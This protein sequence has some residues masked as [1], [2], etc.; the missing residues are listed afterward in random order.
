V[1][2]PRFNAVPG[3]A[4][5]AASGDVLG[6]DAVA[7]LIDLLRIDTSNPGDDSGPGEIAAAEYAADALREVGYA[8]EVFTTSAAHRAG[9]SLLIPG[10]DPAREPLLL[11]G[12][13]DVVPA[14][15]AGWTHPPFAGVM[16]DEGVIWG[17]G[18]VDMKD[19]V[20]MILA[21]VR[22]WA[23]TGYVP[24]RPVA[25][26]LTPDEEAG[27]SRGAHWIVRNRPELLHGATEGIG[28]VGGF[29]VTLPNG[30]R[31]YP[32]QAGE[33]GLAWLTVKVPGTAGH[34]SL[35]HYDNPVE[36]LVAALS[37]L[38]AQPFP[39]DL[40]PSMQVFVETVSAL[41]GEPLALD[42][43]DR[44]TTQV[45]G[46][47]RVL[48]AATRTTINPTML[49]A[50]F[51]HNVVPAFA[52]AGLDIR[53]TPGAEDA[54][55]ERVRAALPDDVELQF[56]HRDISIETSFDGQMVAAI[57][58]VLAERDPEA[59]VVPYLMT[60]GTDAKAFSALGVRYFGF[61][62]LQLAHDSDFWSMFHGI[63]ERVP[64]D[65]LR[66][67]AQVLDEVIRRC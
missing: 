47:A 8:P 58:E 65:G 3:E 34:G 22:H 36:K 50:G 42:D 37:D 55:L 26:L 23:R 19:M 27:G 46:F 24:P 57:V 14:P 61:S 63:D 60:G 16:D 39:V 13:L 54:A 40:S 64:A 21:V 66:F 51:K 12:H 59:V 28:E 44:L 5:S 9:V 29:S 56:A 10:A 7:L 4:A 67:G 32:V 52:A 35:I 1:S 38:R 49:D 30:R 17:R 62:P 25:V 15:P 2:N 48:G 45:G 43:L 11:T 6:D 41:I 20:A 53:F 33:K 18:A 31:I